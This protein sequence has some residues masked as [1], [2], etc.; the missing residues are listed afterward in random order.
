MIVT[1][2]ITFLFDL[3]RFIINLL[4]LPITLLIESFLPDLDSALIAVLAMFDGI[5]SVLGFIVSLSLLPPA[6]FGI[7]LMYYTFSLTFPISVYFIKNLIKWYHRVK[8]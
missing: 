5:S 2:I 8:P 6:F 4:L 7:L 1:A 3:I